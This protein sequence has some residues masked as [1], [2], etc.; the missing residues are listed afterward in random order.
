MNK[1]IKWF[2]FIS[3]VISTCWFIVSCTTTSAK[4]MQDSENTSI[5]LSKVQLSEVQHI[6][7]RDNGLVADFFYNADKQNQQAIILLGGSDG[8]KSWSSDADIPYRKT[9]LDRNCALLSLAYFGIEDLPPMLELIPLEYFNSAIEWI[10]DQDNIDTSKGVLLLGASKGGE[11][12]LLIA[13]QNSNV[14]GV[15][16]IVPASHCFEGIGPNL[17]SSWSKNGQALPHVP[18]IYDPVKFEHAMAT[19]EWV[20]VYEEALHLNPQEVLDAAFIPAEKIKGPIYLLSAKNDKIWPSFAMCNAL[21][22][23]LTAN[24]FDFP[25]QHITFEADH[26]VSITEPEAWLSLLAFLDIYILN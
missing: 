16:A 21:E 2:I 9:L 15:L 23:Y 1:K 8:G 25:V 7:V 18:T 20:E 12:A 24:K 13:S 3:I 19:Y 4:I 11:A 10:L 22:Q 17:L 6:E 14:R 5:L 26:F